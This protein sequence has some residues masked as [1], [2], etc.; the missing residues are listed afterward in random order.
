MSS[1]DRDRFRKFESGATKRK[2]EKMREVE[3]KKM[4]VRY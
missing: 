4:K 1:R 2:K 3:L